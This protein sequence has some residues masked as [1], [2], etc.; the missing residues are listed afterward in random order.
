[1]TLLIAIFILSAFT[2]AMPTKATL[3]ITIDGTLSEGEW[4]DYFWFKDNSEG[5]G[6][7]Y[8][9]DPLPIFTGYL[10]FDD[11]N[12]YIK[13]APIVKITYRMVY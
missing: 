6:T 2:V 4:T 5:P 7:G 13:Y 8:D 3:S 11:K 1:M 10:T 12:L 9:D